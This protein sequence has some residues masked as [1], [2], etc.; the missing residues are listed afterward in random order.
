MPLFR[1]RASGVN[2]LI[3][4]CGG[5]ALALCM[6][7]ASLSG[8]SAGD[9]SQYREFRLGMDVQS[10]AR[11]ASTPPLPAKVLHQ[12]PALL[13]EMEWRPEFLPGASSQPDPVRTGVF[14]FYDGHERH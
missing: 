1:P 14:S 9:L 2:S 5:V 11:L 7:A 4:T 13:Q 10:V 6:G 8:L 3:G 12:K